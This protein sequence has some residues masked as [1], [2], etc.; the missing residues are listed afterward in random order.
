VRLCLQAAN[1]GP[2]PMFNILNG[3]VHA[4]WQGTDL[5]EFIIAPIGAP[6]FA[7]ALRWAAETYHCLKKVLKDGG[8]STGVGDA[9][10]DAMTILDCDRCGASAV[11]TLSHLR[12]R[13]RCRVT[14]HFPPCERG[15]VRSSVAGDYPISRIV[16][17]TAGVSSRPWLIDESWQQ[18]GWRLRPLCR[19]RSIATIFPDLRS[20]VAH[21]N[22]RVSRSSAGAAVAGDAAVRFASNWFTDKA[23]M[24]ATL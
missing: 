24:G 1:R 22:R 23:A 7:E 13:V 18:L 16:L 2:V 15:L 11:P 4:N 17:S 6:N 19:N 14:S 12:T 20:F 10:L 3:G 21:Q 8:H 5:Q 9:R